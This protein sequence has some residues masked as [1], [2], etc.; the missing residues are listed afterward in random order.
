M[1]TKLLLIVL[2]TLEGL[3][4]CGSDGPN[5]VALSGN[6]TRAGQP[7]ESGS[8]SCTPVDGQKGVAA[9]ATIAKGRYQFSGDDGPTPGSYKVLIQETLTKDESM[10]R[11]QD[12]PKNA[13]PINKPWVKEIIVPDSK[14]GSMDFEL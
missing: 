3:P 8:L 6:V 9:N 4:G 11:R 13:A 10:K 7:L 12:Q 2:T 5:R 14:S 1:P